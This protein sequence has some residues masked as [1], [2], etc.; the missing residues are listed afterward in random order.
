VVFITATTMALARWPEDYHLVVLG[1][2]SFV[3]VLVARKAV[4]NKWKIWPI[5]HISG[6]GTS[7]IFLLIAFYVDN[8]RFLPVWKHIPP[9]FYWFLPAIIGFPILVYTLLRNPRSGH[10]F[11]KGK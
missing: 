10:Y 11:M 2:I 8:G 9:A 5:Y 1:G 6:M 4:K 7:Y 3:S